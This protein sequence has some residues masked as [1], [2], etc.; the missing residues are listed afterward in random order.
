M[1]FHSGWWTYFSQDSGQRPKVTRE[2]LLRVFS[3][4]RPYW[5]RIAILFVTI[6]ATAGLALLTPLILQDLIDNAI[7][8]GDYQRLLFLSLGLLAIPLVGGVVGIV[9]RQVNS[10]I[11]EGVIL[12]LRVALFTH[13]QRMSLRFFTN[14]KTGELMSRLNNDVV[15]AQNAITNT[16]VTIVT[17]FVQAIATLAVML[18]IEWRLTLISVAVL[19]FFIIAARRLGD[20]LRTIRREGME[21]NAQMNALMNETLNVSGALLVK[22]FGRTQ[23]EIDRF[24]NRAEGVAEIGVRQAVVGRIF[25]LVIGLVSAIGTALTFGIGGYLALEGVLTVGAI[26][27]FSNYLTQL[28]GTL[29]GLSNAPVEFATSMVSF[30]RVFEVIDLPLDIE[31]RQAALDLTEVRGELAFENVHFR[32][33]P[34]GESPLSEVSRFGMDSV[35]ATLSGGNGQHENDDQAQKVTKSQARELAL[36]RIN[37]KAQP[38]QLIALV[39]PSG[40]GKTTMTY[41]IPRLYDPSEGY[42]TLD[43]HDLRDLSLKSL[44]DHIGMVTQETHLFH[45]S[46]RTNMLYAKP[47]ATQEEIEAACQAANIH[48]FIVGLSDGYDTI[49][50]ERGYR[51]SGGEKQ[52]IALARVILKDPRI[53]VLDE[54]TSHLDSQSEALIQEALNHVQLGRT[55]IVIAHRLST[56][57]AADQILVMDRGEIVERGTHSD[58]LAQGGLYARLYETQFKQSQA[59]PL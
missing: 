12:D 3:Y 13:L 19:P 33:T 24:H 48:E 1:G 9:Q 50:G 14:T 58:L 57:L 16:I 6:L 35:V 44:T 55:S 10:V 29:Q 27:A 17:N 54:A 42:I 22:L 40:A 45:D 21:R 18:A 26:V 36:A 28:Y 37:F 38:G 49:V 56:I 31:E 41:L 32:Y 30:E 47:D 59:A 46:I 23:D 43:G 39:G 52:R 51:L 4:A 8:N 25:F 15:G 34:Q 53:L 5:G 2:L 7:P 20:R 11:G